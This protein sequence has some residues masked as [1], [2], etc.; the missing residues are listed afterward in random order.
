MDDPVILC[1]G[2]TYERLY[3]ENWIRIKKTSPLTNEIILNTVLKSNMA[4]KTAIEA[5]K[6]KQLEMV[7]QNNKSN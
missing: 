1:D 5:Y 6:N 4:L 3:I 2:H 7:Y